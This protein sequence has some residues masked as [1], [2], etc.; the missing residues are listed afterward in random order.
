MF[1][2]L[3]KYHVTM[4]TVYKTIAVNK[5]VLEASSKMFTRVVVVGLALLL[6]ALVSVQYEY[7]IS[8]GMM[9]LACKL[10]TVSGDSKMETAMALCDLSIVRYCNDYTELQ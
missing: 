2:G 6:P 4:Q 10:Y 3:V 7:S 9:L 5:Q 1:I 8:G